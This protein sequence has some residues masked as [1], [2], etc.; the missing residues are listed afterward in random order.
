MKYL[1]VF[2]LDGTLYDLNDVLSANYDM[3]VDFLC[4][5]KKMTQE[6]AIS[7]FDD[8]HIFPEIRKDSMSAT[9]LFYK[10]GL[11]KKE[12]SDFRNLRFDE[13]RIDL[14]KATTE[15]VLREYKCLGEIILLSS[16]AYC[17]IQRILNHLN[18]T[19]SFFDSIICSDRFPID[20]PFK[21]KLAL[22]YLSSQYGIDH[23]Q[24]LSIGDRFATDIEPMLS[25]GGRG[26]QILK[27]SSLIPLV[28][29]IKNDTICTCPEYIY[30]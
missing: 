17:V 27:P 3:Q 16:N 9:E 13:K 28:N 26:V 21:K 24:M 25:L 30:Y 6:E 1:F 19:P 2:D 10:I 11:N 23:S 20:H 8:H 7:F 14:Q 12:W 5:Q 15:D 18:I 29:D 22:E 4:S